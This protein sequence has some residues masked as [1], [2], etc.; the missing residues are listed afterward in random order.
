[1]LIVF[2]V[3]LTDFKKKIELK[4]KA[5]AKPKLS[6]QEYIHSIEDKSKALNF[7]IGRVYNKY[8][9]GSDKIREKLRIPPD[10]YNEFSLIG[11]G[12]NKISYGKL[13]DL[14]TRFELQLKNFEKTEFEVF[15]DAS[16]AL[17]NLIRDPKG[18]DKI[19]DVLEHNDKDPVKSYYEG[20]LEFCAKVKDEIKNKNLKLVKNE[21]IPKDEDDLAKITN[22]PVN[23][24]SSKP[25]SVSSKSSKNSSS[26][27]TIS[28][29]IDDKTD[30][31]DSSLEKDDEL[32]PKF[33]HP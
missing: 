27:K 13:A 6:L 3:F 19:I 26:K 33:S 30:K 21:Y 10:W 31:L 23:K 25:F 18:S 17:K 8:H 22:K 7:V 16:D 1:M 5:K 20:A 29:E 9:G 15:K 24:S 14:I 11:V 12:T 4:E 28:S 2:S 32:K